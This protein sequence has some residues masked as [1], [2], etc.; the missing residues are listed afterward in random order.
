MYNVVRSVQ[1]FRQSRLYDVS[2]P[3]R[4]S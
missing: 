2:L 3:T 1:N 4:E